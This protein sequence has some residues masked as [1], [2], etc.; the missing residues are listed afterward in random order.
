MKDSTLK[1]LNIVQFEMNVIV[2]QRFDWQ[3]TGL[4][5][6]S[7][8][9]YAFLFASLHKRILV[10]LLSHTFLAIKFQFHIMTFVDLDESILNDVNL[11]HAVDH[12]MILF[13]QKRNGLLNHFGSKIADRKF[14]YPKALNKDV[15][16]LMPSGEK[17]SPTIGKRTKN[18]EKS[19]EMLDV[20]ATGKKHC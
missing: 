11:V 16:S 12:E 17:K 7:T 19:R 13:E 2:K 14:Q 9:F 6:R 8:N 4:P 3:P 20:E 15:H 18:K 1:V 10:S 5:S